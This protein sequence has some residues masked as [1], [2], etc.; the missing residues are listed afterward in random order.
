[1]LDY[2]DPD[3]KLPSEEILDRMLD[4]TKGRLFSMR[5]A[6]FL[7]SLLCSHRFVWDESCSTAW[8]NGETIGW[9]P[10]FFYWLTPEERVTVLA[11]ELWHTAFDHMSRLGKLRCPDR[12]NYAADFVINLMLQK[13]G[14]VFGDKLMSLGPCLDPQYDEMTTEQ[15]Y[16]LLPDNPGKPPPPQ[17]DQDPGSGQGKDGSGSGNQPTQDPSKPLAGD[18]RPAPDGQAEKILGNII[19]AI[20][21]SKMSKEAGVIP[22]EIELIVDRFLNPILPWEVLLQKYFTDLSNDDY[23]WKRPSRRYDTEYLPSLMGE[24]G[25]EHL[26]YY[27]DVS[28]SVRDEDVLRFNS[29]VKHI[30]E[31]LRPKLLT[32][33]TFDTKIQDEWEFTDDMPFE[34]IVIHGRGGTS[35]DPVYHHIRKHRPTAAVVF[36]DLYC[37]PMARE[38]GA[39]VLWVVVG[40]KHARTHFGQVIHIDNEEKVS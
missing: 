8:C 19:K 40:N 6:G 7:G 14:Y 17:P 12:W 20:Q 25:L 30:H 35:L 31:N 2:L 36:S 4:K 16:D 28:G 23:S 10:K 39:P 26:I 38:P 15:V 21:A 27:M 29:E 32:L 33:V 37:H 22:G 34:K 5:G 18:L 11:H 13:L 1:M 24:N 3:F 9:N